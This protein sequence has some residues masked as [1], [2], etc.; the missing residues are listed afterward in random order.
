MPGYV[1]FLS[2]SAIGDA[3]GQR[4]T[5]LPTSPNA[6]SS[7]H[8]SYPPTVAAEV[9]V[10]VEVT[11]LPAPPELVFWALLPDLIDGAGNSIA[12]PHMGLQWAPGYPNSRAVNWGGYLVNTGA[13]MTGTTSALPSALNNPNTRDYN[14][15][16]NRQ[17]RYRVWSPSSGVWRAEV[18]DLVTSITTVIRDLSAP[19]ATQLRGAIVFTENFNVCQLSVAARWS[20]LQFKLA[21][22]SLSTPAT[23]TVSYQEYADGGCTNT[24]QATQ[25]GGI[26]QTSGVARTVVAGVNL[27]TA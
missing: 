2:G 7:M 22:N 20:N 27:A 14:W 24:N 15:Q 12:V 23:A 11:S 4:V 16:T 6:A 8:L 9:A 13:E 19:G 26:V 25:G 21:N 1:M 18:T 10:T 5:G 3:S 17:Y